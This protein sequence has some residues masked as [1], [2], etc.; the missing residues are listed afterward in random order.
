MQEQIDK[1]ERD[2][3]AHRYLY[4]IDHPILSDAEFSMLV[5]TAR[6][7][8]DKSSPIHLELFDEFNDY[9]DSVKLR[10]LQLIE[11]QLR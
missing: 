4:Q 3:L 9:S 6:I 5:R 7:F 10:A 1:L 11:E 8:V 2:V